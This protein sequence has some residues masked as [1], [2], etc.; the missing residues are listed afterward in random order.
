[1]ASRTLSEIPRL[2]A[3]CSNA[4]CLLFRCYICPGEAAVNQ[5][6]GGGYV[7]GLLRSQKQGAVG[8]L[9]CLSEPAHRQGG[10]P[11]FCPPPVPGAKLFLE[12]RGPPRR[13]KGGEPHPPPGAIPAP[14]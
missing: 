2:R 1:M 13:A 12:R 11:L 5:E 9:G 10:G 6:G 14:P 3:P 7:R 8:D 4:L